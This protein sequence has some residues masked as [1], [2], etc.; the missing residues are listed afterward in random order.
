MNS[1]RNCQERIHH[2]VLFVM[3]IATVFAYWA[4]ESGRFGAGKEIAILGGMTVKFLG[5]S[6]FF[7]DLKSAHRLYSVFSGVFI[8]LMLVAFGTAALN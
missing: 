1:N 8:F 7:M 5:I 3:L 2:L 6:W 4:A